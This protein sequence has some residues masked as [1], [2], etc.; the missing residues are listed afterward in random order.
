MLIRVCS[1]V[2]MRDFYF[3]T[4]YSACIDLVVSTSIVMNAWGKW[5]A[6]IIHSGMPSACTI[7]VIYVENGPRRQNLLE[8]IPT[9][10][11]W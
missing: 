11:D 5:T 10:E 6:L 2:L 8:R 1:S 9:A 3:F 7:V 4:C